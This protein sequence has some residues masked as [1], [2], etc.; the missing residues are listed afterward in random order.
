MMII[1]AS[2]LSSTDLS[3]L[4][5]NLMPAVRRDHRQRRQLRAINR[6]LAIVQ[7]QVHRL[8][9][10]QFICSAPR[11]PRAPHQGTIQ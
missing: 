11:I 6:S 4:G 3:L 7:E 1:P 10:R 2:R 9:P 5:N 8:Y